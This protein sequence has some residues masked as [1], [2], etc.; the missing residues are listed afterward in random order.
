MHQRAMTF[1]PPTISLQFK[2]IPW[3]NAIKFIG[4]QDLSF[5]YKTMH[6]NKTNKKTVLATNGNIHTIIHWK[7]L[8]RFFMNSQKKNN[9]CSCIVFSI[10][11]FLLKT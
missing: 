10:R 9:T 1:S 3:K 2:K 5:L 6:C 7:I 11:I 4:L 8:M